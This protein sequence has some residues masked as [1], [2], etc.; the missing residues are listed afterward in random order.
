MMGAGCDFGSLS[1]SV[2]P[3]LA[4]DQKWAA[5]SPIVI[6]YCQIGLSVVRSTHMAPEFAVIATSDKR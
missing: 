3:R 6:H 5:L 4:I 2:L 1:D